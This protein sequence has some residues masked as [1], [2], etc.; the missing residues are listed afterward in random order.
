M[1]IERVTFIY[2]KK[3]VIIIIFHEIGDWVIGK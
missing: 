1:V 3:K 2:R